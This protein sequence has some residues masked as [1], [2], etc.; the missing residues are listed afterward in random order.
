MEMVKN[1][2]WQNW[3]FKDLDRKGMVQIAVNAFNNT[4]ED[5]DVSLPGSFK[6]TLKENFGRVRWFLNHD[7]TI[8]LGVPVKGYETNDHLVMEA[9]FN[10]EKQ[11]A[12]DTYEDYK[13]Y[14]EHDKTL[15]HSV[16]LQA[17]KYEIDKDEQTRKVSEWKLW[18]F[19]TLTS[20]GANQ[21]TPLMNIKSQFNDDEISKLKGLLEKM[22]SNA[23]YSDT[24]KIEVEQTYTSLFIKPSTMTLEQ[25]ADMKGFITELIKSNL[26]IKPNF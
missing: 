9:R 3:Q 19:S 18:E 22:G 15:E 8:L 16:G 11:I 25:E 2:S 7:T 23:N 13:L 1:K 6:K 12:R 5:G 26:F 10:M 20:W 14:A 4:D 21:N 24:R 17:I